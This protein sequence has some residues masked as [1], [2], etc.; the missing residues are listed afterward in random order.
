MTEDSFKAHQGFDLA[1]WDTGLD[2]AAAPKSYRLLK[3]TTIAECVKI[4]ANDIGKDPSRIRLWVMVNRQNKTVRPD[5]PLVETD[6][7]LDEA[8]NKYGT[9]NSTFRVWAE[10]GETVEDD[11]PMWPDP[12]LQMN[13]NSPI[14]IFL[15]HFD[16]ETQ[17]L[18]GVGHV[19]IRRQER[20]QDLAAPILQLMGWQP[21]TTLKLYEVRFNAT[22]STRM[23]D[24]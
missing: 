2:S 3:T 23:A 10:V 11:K 17:T 15:K 22:A 14:L 8:Y 4:L 5:Q 9:K 12:Q 16:A 21:G 19:Y 6:M 18:L 13:S 20:V 24:E 1:T 7:T